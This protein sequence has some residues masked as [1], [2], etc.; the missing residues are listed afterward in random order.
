MCVHVILALPP[1]TGRSRLKGKEII[2]C[3]EWHFLHQ[4][5]PKRR[6]SLFGGKCWHF[7]YMHVK[8]RAW[9]ALN[10]REI[11]KHSIAAAKDFVQPR[12]TDPN[13]ASTPESS[14]SI[15]TVLT[16][17]RHLSLDRPS[18]KKYWV[19]GSRSLPFKL[20][21]DRQKSLHTLRQWD[22]GFFSVSCYL[23]HSSP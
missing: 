4:P 11:V 8:R 9:T 18:Y 15:S 5:N 13:E 19:W 3:R 17:E 23:K 6:Q 7:L 10:F 20:P 22:L 21:S 16:I 14:W 12:F 1:N 2:Y